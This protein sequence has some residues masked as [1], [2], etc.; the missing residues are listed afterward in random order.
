MVTKVPRRSAE[1]ANARF[2]A[3]P[4]VF[5]LSSCGI[6]L[7]EE[8]ERLESTPDVRRGSPGGT[9]S[10]DSRCAGPGG[11]QIVSALRFLVSFRVS[12]TAYPGIRPGDILQTLLHG[13]C[14]FISAALVKPVPGTDVRS[15]A[16]LHRQWMRLMESLG[17]APRPLGMGGTPRRLSV[18]VFAAPMHEKQTLPRCANRRLVCSRRLLSVAPARERQQQSPRRRSP[19]HAAARP[20]DLNLALL[21]LLET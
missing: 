9:S 6:A 10:A 18:R 12:V 7:E 13:W 3:R 19:P 4:R 15:R 16:R 5:R 2:A 20:G 1:F 8:L 17:C 11:V 21:R 14:A